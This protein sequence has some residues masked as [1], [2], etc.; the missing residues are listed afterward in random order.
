[1]PGNRPDFRDMKKLVMLPP[2][3]LFSLCTMIISISSETVGKKKIP[4]YTDF[5]VYHSLGFLISR[6]ENCHHHI[7]TVKFPRCHIV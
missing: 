1:M 5:N 2:V 3:I 6:N 4:F 7:K